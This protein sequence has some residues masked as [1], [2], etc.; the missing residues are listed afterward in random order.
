MNED[1]LKQYKERLEEQLQLLIR[2]L[3]KF[4]TDVCPYVAKMEKQ[5]TDDEARQLLD[6]F[7]LLDI[8]KQL[9]RMDNWRGIEKKNRSV[10]QTVLK[11]FE[12]DVKAGRYEYIQNPNLAKSNS[13]IKEK[14]INFTRSEF[15]KAHPVGSIVN[16][17]L[18]YQYKIT[19]EYQ[20]KDIKTGEIV[21]ID[22]IIKWLQ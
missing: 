18:G 7:P 12:M 3:K 17:G 19:N 8:K 14:E 6:K 10:Y 9:I 16:V 13:I 5:L 11:W 15:L 4:I 1:E 21:S 22:K 20:A 2:N